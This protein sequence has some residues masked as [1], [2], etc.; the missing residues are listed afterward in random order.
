MFK[1]SGQFLS[2]H[3]II[4]LIEWYQTICSC[5]S[6]NG[7]VKAVALQHIQQCI[8]FQFQFL[9]A[10]LT[11]V[12]FPCLSI[13][14]DPTRSKIWIILYANC[15]GFVNQDCWF[16]VMKKKNKKN[17][18][19]VD[20]S[21]KCNWITICLRFLTNNFHRNFDVHFAVFVDDRQLVHSG[22]TYFT[23]V[24][25]QNS[26]FVGMTHFI[27]TSIFQSNSAIRPTYSEMSMQYFNCWICCVERK[28]LKHLCSAK[29]IS[30][31]L[32]RERTNWV[33]GFRVKL[34]AESWLSV[35][36]QALKAPSFIY[37]CLPLTAK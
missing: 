11:V 25:R 28:K 12:C 32:G 10:F 37:P 34:Q 4:V 33:C 16:F 2:I 14:V 21:L 18:I 8:C 35:L 7:E 17:K 5:K 9:V 6:K 19:Y 3:L 13:S 20:L 23:G 27:T 22:V 15:V 24:H 31:C 29:V 26:H 36:L 30:S 1:T